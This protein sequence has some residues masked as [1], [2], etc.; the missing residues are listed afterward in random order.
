MSF[1]IIGVIGLLLALP[2][3]LV[4]CSLKRLTLAFL[5][6]VFGILV[7]LLV[8]LL[9]AFLTPE[10]KG[11]CPH[12]WLDCFHL[13]KLALAPV[14]LWALISFYVAEICRPTRPLARD[15]VMGLFLGCAVAGACFAYGAATL[16]AESARMM[17]YLIVPLYTAVWHGVRLVQAHGRTRPNPIWY[18]VYL[19]GSL[20]F[21]IAGL[22]W[23]RRIFETL[24]NTP[25]ECFVVTAASC[26]HKRLVGPFAE[27]LHRGNRRIANQQLMALWNFEQLWQERSPQ[28][29]YRFRHRYNRFGPMIARQINSPLKADV[30]HYALKP[31][32]WMAHLANYVAQPR[33]AHTSPL[34]T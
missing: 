16:R 34:H 3:L 8:F 24:P 12:G 22:V 33:N 5:A 32:E 25:P 21:W 6:S 18:L 2:S 31:V 20:P 19:L 17:V 23:S 1:F 29:L 30:V 15:L 14:V 9:S 27:T 11:D 26:G 10:W 28:T 7:P 13:G 4:E